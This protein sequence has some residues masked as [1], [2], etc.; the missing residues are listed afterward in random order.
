M[1]T[2]DDQRRINIPIKL[3]E[4]A[5]ILTGTEIALFYENNRIFIA[6]ASNELVDQDIIDFRMLD[7]SGRIILPE[8]VL[9]ILE[10]G[11]EDSL[12]VS[13]RDKRISIFKK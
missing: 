12:I 11:K 13:L 10:V 2:V 7:S 5:R 1:P 9:E 4:K 6:D 8:T 3:R